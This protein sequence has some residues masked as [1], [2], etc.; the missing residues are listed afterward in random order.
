METVWYHFYRIQSFEDYKA[1]LKKGAL[2]VSFWN[3]RRV[4]VHGYSDSLG[5]SDLIEKVYDLI[6]CNPDYPE[7]ERLFGKEVAAMIDQLHSQSEHVKQSALDLRPKYACYFFS[8]LFDTKPYQDQFI[9]KWEWGGRKIFDYYTAFQW[10]QKFGRDLPNP[11]KKVM[12]HPVCLYD[13]MEQLSLLKTR[14]KSRL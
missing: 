4:A 14:T 1:F 6:K 3:G 11:K 9:S 2:N 10:K 5:I 12:K 7:K 13:P 8:V